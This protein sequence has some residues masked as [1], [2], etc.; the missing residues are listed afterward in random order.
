MIKFSPLVLAQNCH[1]ISLACAQNGETVTIEQ[2]KSS[3]SCVNG[4]VT[5]FKLPE[6]SPDASC[7]GGRCV[8]NEGSKGDGFNCEYSSALFVDFSFFFQI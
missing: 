8:C 4:N 2:C 7:I 3:V 6:C 1:T 5:Y